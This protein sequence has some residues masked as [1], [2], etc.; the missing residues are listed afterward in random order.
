MHVGAGGGFCAE[1]AFVC[2]ILPRT[3]MY[4]FMARKAAL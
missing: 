2:V 3:N 4:C 1:F